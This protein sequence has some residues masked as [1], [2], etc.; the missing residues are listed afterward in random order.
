MHKIMD[1]FVVKELFSDVRLNATDIVV[2]L[3][4]YRHRIATMAAHLRAT[5]F[6]RETF[7]RSVVKLIS[8]GWAYAV[9]ANNSRSRLI[10][11]EAPCTTE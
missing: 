6:A 5:N 2:W 9:Q 7:R 10:V 8:L 4:L 3:H 1:T 11:P